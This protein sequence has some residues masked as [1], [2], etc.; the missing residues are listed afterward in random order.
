MRAPTIT[1]KVAWQKMLIGYD[2]AVFGSLAEN[3][4]RAFFPSTCPDGGGGDV[5]N[6]TNSTST[7]FTAT[8]TIA[9]AT[10]ASA[11][12]CVD[13]NLLEV[14]RALPRF[15]ERRRTRNTWQRAAADVPTCTRCVRAL[16]VVHATRNRD[17][18]IDGSR[19][20]QLASQLL[21]AVDALV[22]LTQ[23]HMSLTRS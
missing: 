2:F 11:H 1:D 3:I 9:N 8:T 20:R 12:V 6:V 17:T 16:A 5:G 15:T 18:G 19:A 14:R 13:D 10:A 21:C 22:R 23:N 4:G 7:A